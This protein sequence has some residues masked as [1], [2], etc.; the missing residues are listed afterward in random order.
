MLNNAKIKIA[1]IDDDEDD[2]FLIKDY[3]TRIEGNDF[4]VDWCNDYDEAIDKIK[5]K[6]HK[7]SLLSRECKLQ[8]YFTGKGRIDYFVVVEHQKTSER[9]RHTQNSDPLTGIEKKLFQKLED[10]YQG[11]KDDIENQAGVVHDFRDLRSANL[12]KEYKY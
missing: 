11:V 12:R 3:I 5:A 9:S 2:Y 7:S 1:I 8:T 6:D 4:T 10:D